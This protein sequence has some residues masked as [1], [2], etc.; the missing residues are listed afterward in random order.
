ML[1]NSI[2]ESFGQIGPASKPKF[3]ICVP[4][5]RVQKT[6]QSRC[7]QK[8]AALASRWVPWINYDASKWNQLQS[9]WNWPHSGGGEGRDRIFAPR[10]RPV[11]LQAGP[12]PHVRV[13]GQLHQ[14]AQ[15]PA[16][17]VH[18]EQRV[19]ELHNSAGKFAHFPIL[20]I[21]VKH[22]LTL[23]YPGY[24]QQG[25]TRNVAMHCLRFWGAKKSHFMLTPNEMKARSISPL[26]G[27]YIR[28]R[29]AT[30]HLPIGEGLRSAAHRQAAREGLEQLRP[31]RSRSFFGKKDGHPCELL[32]W[33]CRWQAIVQW[34][35]WNQQTLTPKKKPH[36][37]TSSC[38]ICL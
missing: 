14:E 38:V 27:V 31:L 37:D 34:T 13:H 36:S 28:A 22:Y 4:G 12:Q 9:I 10:G 25:D 2:N 19:G 20:E 11:R 15:E 3:N 29:S 1:A 21:C 30:P 18:D 32:K 17:E 33:H 26:A 7:P 6:W 35:A 8:S 16:G 5:T 24:H 23:F